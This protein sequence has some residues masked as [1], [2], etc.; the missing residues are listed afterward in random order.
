MLISTF[1][2]RLVVLAVWGLGSFAI[3][4]STCN[5]MSGIGLFLEEVHETSRSRNRKQKHPARTFKPEPFTISTPQPRFGD[6]GTSIASKV[7]LSF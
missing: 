5:L 4:K 3:R 6:H 1:G 7:V 2:F